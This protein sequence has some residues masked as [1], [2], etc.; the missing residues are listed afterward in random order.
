MDKVVAI[1]TRLGVDYRFKDGEIIIDDIGGTIYEL[2]GEIGFIYGN[3][4]PSVP[5]DSPLLE[6]WVESYTEGNEA[7]GSFLRSLKEVA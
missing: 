5:V 7:F 3:T 4:E 1:L 6:K 2:N